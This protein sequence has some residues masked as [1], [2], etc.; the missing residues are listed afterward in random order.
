V[1]ERLDVFVVCTPGLE[2]LVAAEIER[3]GVRSPRVRHGGVDCSVTLPQL[4]SLNLRLR[5]ATRVL[6]RIARFEADTFATLQAGLRRLDWA[7]WIAP[8]TTVDLRAASSAASTL[9]HSGAIEERAAEV[10]AAAGYPIAVRA[11]SEP[12]E[13][14]ETTEPTGP[15]GTT[16]PGEGITGPVQ[17]VHLR[18]AKNVVLV[19]IDASGAP[20]YRRGWRIDTGKAPLRETLAAALVLHSGW[21]RKAA[22][23]DP[24]C[25][26]GTIV[27]EAALLARRMAPG[28]NRAF[29]FEH[30]PS[31]DEAG[32]TRLRD[33]ALAD[34][35]PGKAILI[36]ADRDAGATAAAVANATRAGVA[37]DIEFR[38]ASISGLSLPGRAGWLVTNPPYGHRIGGP[39][40]G[41]DL[42][43]LYDRF[44]SV[45]A[46]R[47]AGWSV[48]IVAAAPE[49]DP[50]TRWVDRL[51]LEVTDRLATI[52]G[53]LPVE[54]V[55]GKVTPRASVPTPR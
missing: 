5:T 44:G 36:G 24:F 41:G 17:V 33:G 43:D 27:I 23:V 28:R 9:Y 18:L 22:F 55:S 49:S 26:S 52:N 6:V 10:M 37:D 34:V 12:T 42:R 32:W 48:A 25:G 21:N 50:A 46:E 38:E 45:M 14:T 20:L 53:G 40:A 29:A 19:S 16:P 11:P 15:T 39:A 3:L 1:S 51:P 2:P 31:F 47:A 7:K 30:W 13:T 35:V 54:F 4:W 8:T